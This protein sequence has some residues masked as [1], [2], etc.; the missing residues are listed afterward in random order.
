LKSNKPVLIW[1]ITGAV[2]V[3]SMVVIGGIT[4]LTNSGLSMVEWKLVMGS[5]P[6]LSEKEWQATFEKYQQF[7]EYQKINSNYKLSDFKA[8]FWWEYSHRLLG[9]IIGIVFLIPFIVFWLKGNFNKGWLWRLSLLFVLG[10]LQ[11]LLGWFMVKSGLIDNPDV[12]HYRLAAHLIAALL[13]FSY[14]I[15]LIMTWVNETKSE[16]KIQSYNYSLWVLYFLTLIQI[17]YG[18]LVAGLNAGVFYTTYPKM[19]GAWIPASISEKITSTGWLALVSDVTTVQFIHRWLGT[20]LFFL[21]V[22]LY[23]VYQPSLLTQNKKRL[24]FLLGAVTLQVL[25]GI[26]TLLFTVPFILAVLHQ[27]TALIVLGVLIINLHGSRFVRLSP[28]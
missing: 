15:W 11:G 19:N 22:V 1:L 17:T 27:F 12:S 28:V 25:L 18:A 7:P 10:G 21:V 16:I 20:A 13:L 24:H 3:A 2:L 26:L 6:P 14:I 4:R 23:Y 9:R 8:I 5:I